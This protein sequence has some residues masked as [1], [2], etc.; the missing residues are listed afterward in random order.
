MKVI[1]NGSVL[2]LPAGTTVEEARA[3]LVGIYPE[4]ANA[5]AEIRVDGIEFVV[6][7][8]TKG[9]TGGLV[10][11]Y[12]GSTLNLPAGTTVEEARAALVGI[13]PEIANADATLN[14]QGQLVF[15]VKAGTKGN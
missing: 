12:N 15:T 13:Y 8:G 9:V 10:V 11:V 4:I 6:K 14:A 5:S 3:A 7:A 2:N 1:Y